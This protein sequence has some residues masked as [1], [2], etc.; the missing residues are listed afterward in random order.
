MKLETQTGISRIYIDEPVKNLSRY[1]PN[2]KTVFV[3]DEKVF[4]LYSDLF[5]NQ[6]VI[7]IRRGEHVKTLDTVDRIYRQFLELEVDRFSF[8]VG[9]GG[10]IVCDIAGFCASTYM[11]GLH[12]GFVPTTLVAQVDASIG[13]KNGVNLMG[14]KN[15]IGVIRQP[16]FILVDFSFLKTLPER[17]FL[18]GVSEIIKC[19]LIKSKRLFEALEEKQEKFLTQSRD[20]FREITAEAIAIKTEVVRRDAEEFGERR[21]LNFGH[22]LGHAIEKTANYPHGEAISIG[23]SMASDISVSMGIL[24]KQDAARIKR[25]LRKV[26]L[27]CQLSCEVDALL[28]AIKKDKKRSSE[29]IHFVL[30]AGIGKGKV[31]KISYPELEECI[32]DLYEHC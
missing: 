32:H 20:V 6:N 4:N 16:N 26:N 29:E 10:G 7:Q 30:L 2:A 23:M 19:A 13:G 15:I 31:V 12:F 8:I 22:T 14:Y 9:I 17:D 28:E 1:V 18:C 25:L 11:R 5:P 24:S 21:I 27:P 3:T